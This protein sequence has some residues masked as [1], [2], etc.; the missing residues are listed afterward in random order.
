MITRRIQCLELARIFHR[1][2]AEAQ[3][4]E[5]RAARYSDLAYQYEA[6]AAHGEVHSGRAG[7]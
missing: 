7:T 2:A 1:C 5:Q 6:E 3:P 4:D